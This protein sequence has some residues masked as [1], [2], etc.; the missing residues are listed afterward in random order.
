[1]EFLLP[2]YTP[3]IAEDEAQL[4]PTGVVDRLYS[5]ALDYLMGAPSSTETRRLSDRR[6]DAGLASVFGEGVTARA[7]RRAVAVLLGTRYPVAYLVVENFMHISTQRGTSQMHETLQRV[8][9][10]F[11]NNTDK[12]ALAEVERI[13]LQL[14]VT[15]AKCVREDAAV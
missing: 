6:D 2:L 12:E 15:L 9:R 1:V 10:D 11:P 5:L 4:T 14:S 8:R 3:H 7:Y 13:V